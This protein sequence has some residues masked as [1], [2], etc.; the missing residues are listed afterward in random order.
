V[1]EI[2]AEINALAAKV[3]ELTEEELWEIRESLE[4][5]S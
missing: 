4:E 2:K 5:L 1:W 3:W